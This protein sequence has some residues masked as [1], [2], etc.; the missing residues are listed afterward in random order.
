MGHKENIIEILKENELGLKYKAL[1]N[2]YEEKFGFKLSNQEK[3]GYYYLKRLMD[4][5]LVKTYVP[6]GRKGKIIAYKLTEKALTEKPD[7]LKFLIGL[8]ERGAMKFY[9]SK[10]KQDDIE[11]LEVM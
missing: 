4:K 10:L 9:K 7:D 11:R 8:I 3:N 2:K 5:D 1:Y 6:E